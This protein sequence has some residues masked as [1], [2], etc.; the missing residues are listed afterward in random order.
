MAIWQHFEQILIIFSL[1]MRRCSYL[2]AF[3][4]N[5]DIIMQF[6]DP[7]FLKQMDIILIDWDNSFLRFDQT[8]CAQLWRY[9]Y[10]RSEIWYSYIA[11]FLRAVD[12]MYIKAFRPKFW[13]FG[14]IR[15]IFSHIS[16]CY[17]GASYQNCDTIIQLGNNDFPNELKDTYRLRYISCIS[18]HF[19]EAHVQ[20]WDGG[21]STSGPKS[22]TT[23][24]LDGII[25]YTE[26]Q[27]APDWY[28]L[29]VELILTVLYTFFFISPIAIANSMG[30]II[31][32]FCVCPCVCVSVCGHSHGRISSSIFTKLNTDV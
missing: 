10:F 18:D 26:V 23:I 7:D 4:Q 12:F 24:I 17:L 13:R 9:F 28:L 8:L 11:I 30:Q 25:L 5:S 21:I 31:K 27:K 6:G 22:D 32:S 15:T 16:L 20:R 14:N 19:L 29:D 3:W 1:R 2:W